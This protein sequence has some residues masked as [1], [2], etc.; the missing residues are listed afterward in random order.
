LVPLDDGELSPQVG[1]IASGFNEVNFT[2]GV[3]LKRIEPA[4]LGGGNV[5]LTLTGPSDVW[6]G[7]GFMDKLPVFTPGT[8]SGSTMTNTYAVV[9]LGDGSV[10]ER[11]LGHHTP[12]VV[13]NATLEVISNV[14]T[15]GIRHVQLRRKLAGLTPDHYTFK[16]GAASIGVIN[17]IGSTPAF[18]YHKKHSTS[19]LFFVD[20]GAPT[21]VCDDAPPLGSTE[22]QGTIGRVSFRSNCAPRPFS[23]MI[24]DEHWRNASTPYT[25]NNGV[26]P[27]CQLSACE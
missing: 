18:G 1:A 9:V 7:A 13:L 25:N 14:V 26:N 12:G 19:K 2:N 24:D 6:F 16:Q 21:C 10:Q 5:T 15:D 4:S 3:L 11:K 27:T 8:H 17:A 20:A 23:Q 22:S